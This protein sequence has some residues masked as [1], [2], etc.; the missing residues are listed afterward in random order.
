MIRCNA[1]C[2]LSADAAGRLQGCPGYV[3]RS[4]PCLLDAPMRPRSILSALVWENRDL[5]V[6]CR[7]ESNLSYATGVTMQDT[8]NVLFVLVA[9]AGFFLAM[10]QWVMGHNDSGDNTLMAYAPRAGLTAP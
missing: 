5:P 3:A 1:L 6:G 2:G 4:L 7:F 9:G 10:Y 8:R